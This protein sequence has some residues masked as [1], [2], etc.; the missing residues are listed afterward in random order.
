MWSEYRFRVVALPIPAFVFLIIPIISIAVAVFGIHSASFIAGPSDISVSAIPARGLTVVS[1]QLLAMFLTWARLVIPLVILSMSTDIPLFY[2]ESDLRTGWLSYVASFNGINWLVQKTVIADLGGFIDD[3]LSLDL[4]YTGLQVSTYAA[5]LGICALPW[6]IS[7]WWSARMKSGRGTA[8]L[9]FF[10]G[11]ILF[12]AFIGGLFLLATAF[13]DVVLPSARTAPHIETFR[14]EFASW[15]RLQLTDNY[16]GWH[17]GTVFT[18]WTALV[19]GFLTTLHAA[20]IWR[21]GG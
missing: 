13:V 8:I 10:G 15:L 17:N 11:I 19:V 3:E 9:L 16:S 20:K 4:K 18:G 7:L 12:I 14:I 1:S 21:R 5:Y 6:T 2:G